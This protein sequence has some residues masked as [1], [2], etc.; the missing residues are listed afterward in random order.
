MQRQRRRKNKYPLGF[1]GPARVS[2]ERFE[3]RVLLSAATG[4]DPIASETAA[5][6]MVQA[7]GYAAQT[8][9]QHEL[10]VAATGNIFLNDLH[11]DQLSSA[12]FTHL[13]IEGSDQTND[14]LIVDLS[15]GD[16]PL[17]VTFHGG[18]GG[19]DSL[20]VSGVSGGNYTP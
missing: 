5:V 6:A 16:V 4:T 18:I 14:T 17:A 8:T 3:Q 10:T 12:G 19:Y 15:H 13:I 11:P 20:N 1:S 7:S 2:V 9:G